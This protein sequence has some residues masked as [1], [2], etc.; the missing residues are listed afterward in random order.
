MGP[1][2]ADLGQNWTP[3]ALAEFIKDPTERAENDERLSKLARK[4]PT[5]MAPNRT[6]SALERQK[7]AEWLLAR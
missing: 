1:S 3:G 7:I 2:L 4:F 5:R 6:L